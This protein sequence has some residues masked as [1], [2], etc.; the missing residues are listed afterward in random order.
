MRSL[1]AWVLDRL[2]LVGGAVLLLVAGVAWFEFGAFDSNDPRGMFVSQTLVWT[3][4]IG[5]YTARM[6]KARHHRLYRRWPL[7]AT[8]FVSFA[9]HVVILG[10]II[11]YGHPTW[12]FPQWIVIDFVE[13]AIVSVLIEVSYQ[14]CIQPTRPPVR[15][16]AAQLTASF[17]AQRQDGS[18]RD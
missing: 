13:L 15:T 2:L 3:P 17:S 6:I 7:I 8:G 16:I 5:V 11:R 14:Y 12:Q 9:L 10:S 4:L 18:D 1:A